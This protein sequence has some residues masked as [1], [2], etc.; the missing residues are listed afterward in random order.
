M[1]FDYQNI[2][3]IR[4]QALA[5]KH[6]CS[7]KYVYS[8]LSGERNDNTDLAKSIIKDAQAIVDIIDERVNDNTNRFTDEMIKQKI[9]A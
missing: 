4:I 9:S 5:Y 8:V 2:K 7:P 3:K 6:G 1:I